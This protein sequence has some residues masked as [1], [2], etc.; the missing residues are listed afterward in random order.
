MTTFLTLHSQMLKP[1]GIFQLAKVNNCATLNFN[2]HVR[3]S[4][5]VFQ[6]NA[7]HRCSI[8]QHIVTRRHIRKYKEPLLIHDR[9]RR[10]ALIQYP[11]YRFAVIVL[12]LG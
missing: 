4:L 6:H 2:N 1:H 7:S 11:H 10:C 12:Y 9:S 5:G 3:T 8:D